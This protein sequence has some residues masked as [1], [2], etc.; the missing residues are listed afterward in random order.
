MYTHD[1]TSKHQERS[2]AINPSDDEARNPFNLDCSCADESSHNAKGAG[3][4]TVR[5]GGGRRTGP[6]PLNS[7]DGYAED[8][9]AKDELQDADD[10]SRDH[11]GSCFACSCKSGFKGNAN[12]DY[13]VAEVVC[14]LR[15]TVL[16]AVIL[17]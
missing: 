11:L 6:L 12:E 3:K 7:L 14:I 16:A 9:G 4:G 17:D 2:Q 10:E 5:S 13:S 8:D 15:D 1:S